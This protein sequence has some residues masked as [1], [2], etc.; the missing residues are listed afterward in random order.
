V[1]Q[2]S[3][4][5]VEERRKRLPLYHSISINPSGSGLFSKANHPYIGLFIILKQRPWRWSLA[6]D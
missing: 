4:S 5:P 1:K 3:S 2:P 6:E